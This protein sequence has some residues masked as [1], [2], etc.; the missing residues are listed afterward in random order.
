MA[1]HNWVDVFT[2]EFEQ[3]ESAVQARIWADVL[4]DEYPAELAP[5]SYTTWSELRRMA[6]A[7][8]VGSGDVLVD[9]GCGRGGPGLWVAAMTGA[10]YVGVDIAVPA[11]VAVTRRAERL[12]LSSQVR[13]VAASFDALSLDDGKAGAVMSIDA[14]LF[15]PDKRAAATEMARVLRPGGR[16][17]ATTWDYHSQPAGRPPQVCDHR[18]VLADVGL[19]VEVYDETADWSHRQRA[20]SERLLASVDELAIESGEDPVVLRQ[21]LEE[22]AATQDTMSRRVFIV[23]RRR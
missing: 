20:I 19:D 13:T 21:G 11:L 5:Y 6:N 12:G 1:D 17:V 22:M 10:R 3:P 15:A 23:A 16:L 14:L 18:P 7:L 9:V 4:G 2:R 8:A